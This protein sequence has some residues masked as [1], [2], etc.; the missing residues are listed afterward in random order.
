M[1]LAKEFI[2]WLVISHALGHR[3][4]EKEKEFFLV[5]TQTSCFYKL[6]KLMDMA[7]KGEQVSTFLHSAK[8]LAQVNRWKE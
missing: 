6:A 4:L 2:T 1:C 8:F 5:T 3:N 7:G